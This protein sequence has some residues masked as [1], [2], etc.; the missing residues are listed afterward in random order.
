MQPK[1]SAAGRR[2]FFLSIG[3]ANVVDSGA[4]KRGPLPILCA[5][6]LVAG[7]STPPPPAEEPGE[8]PPAEE[9]EAPAEEPAR[10]DAPKAPEVPGSP[11]P[12]P[13]AVKLEHGR[14]VARVDGV[15]VFLDAP[16]KT[17]WKA[18]KTSATWL[19]RKATLSPLLDAR[20]RPLVSGRP[21]R[22]CLDPGHG[23]SDP[24]AA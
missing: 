21:F 17:D 12:K 15:Q 16:A 8:E 22:V 13:W 1:T 6:L 3:A 14:A 24:G 19:D 4:M 23:G 7:C 2:A 5:L 18:K 9:P 20:S 11:E 10:T